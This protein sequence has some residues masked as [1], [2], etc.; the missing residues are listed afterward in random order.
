DKSSTI[1]WCLDDGTGV[2]WVEAAGSVSQD[3]LHSIG[4]EVMTESS[5]R[6]KL[7]KEQLGH[8]IK[9]K[10]LWCCISVLGTGKYQ[11]NSVLMD[12]SDGSRS[13]AQAD[14]H[15]MLKELQSKC[16]HR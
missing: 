1:K 7:T 13:L 4:I 8:N 12:Y 2:I 15:K 9:G 6:A 16:E 5:I 11:F 10:M 14:C 3:I